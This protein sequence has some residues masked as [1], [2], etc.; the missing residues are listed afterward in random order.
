M[1]GCRYVALHGL[2]NASVLRSHGTRMLVA[3]HCLCTAQHCFALHCGRAA[4]PKEL[5][6]NCIALPLAAHCLALACEYQGRARAIVHAIALH[7]RCHTVAL[8]S[9][10][11]C[12]CC[13][14]ATAALAAESG[15]PRSQRD[16]FAMPRRWHCCFWEVY[17]SCSAVRLRC[18]DLHRTPIARTIAARCSYTAL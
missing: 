16:G 1:G 4:Q 2:C 18:M 12:C 13:C 8:R 15:C 11:C 3:L 10:W 7:V 14:C 5:H 6:C 9:G 17:C